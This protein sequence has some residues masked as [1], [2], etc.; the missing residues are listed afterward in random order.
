[1][2]KQ[3]SHNASFGESLKYPE[4]NRETSVQDVVFRKGST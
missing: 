1:M 2:V 3:N 4:E